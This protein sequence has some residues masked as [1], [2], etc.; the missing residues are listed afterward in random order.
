MTKDA[1]GLS[2]GADA[3]PDAGEA[4]EPGRLSA[5]LHSRAVTL[6]LAALVFAVFVFALRRLAAEVSYAELVAALSATPYG[7]L[8][9]AVA[10]TAASYAALTVYD[11]EGLAYAGEK[12]PYRAVAFVAFCAY[13]VGNTAGF[14]PLSGGAI[15]YRFYSRLGLSPEA[16]AKVI[17]FVTAAFGLGLLAVVVVA[18]AVS[19]ERLGAAIGV[20]PAPLRIA[21]FL[22]LALG[23]ALV[24][25]LGRGRRLTLGRV[26][27]ALPGARI[28]ASQLVVTALDVS[29]AALALYALLP[30]EATVGY[31][32]FLAIY[33]VAIGIGVLS[34]VPAGLGVFET[35]MV[36]ALG[37][38]VPTTALISSLL[39]YRVVY[40]VLPLVIAAL[41]V[42][43]AETRQ[44]FT[45]PDGQRLRAA[46]TRIA[47]PVLATLAVI[48]GLTLVL[49]SVTPAPQGDLDALSSY[50][51]LPLVEAA[52]FLSG[53]LGL[54]LAIAGRGLNQRLDGAWA[55]ALV[56]SLVSLVLCFAKALAVYEAAL[57]AVLV[58]ALLVTRREFDRPASLWRQRLTGP[59]LF[60]IAIIV[61]SAA[62]ILLFVYKD[63]AYTHE[64]WL[65]FEF[66]SDAPRS[67]RAFVGIAV[68]AG[69]AALASLLRP[70]RGTV[71]APLPADIARAAAIV[72]TQDVSDANLVRCADKS[73]LFSR[74]G[75][76][77]VMYGRHGRSFI[78]LFEPIGTPA[79]QRDLVW[80]FVEMAR[81]VGG[82]A[83]FYQVAPSAVALCADAGLQ[84]LK[85]GEMAV[86]DL[87]R[88]DLK[89]A[90]RSGLR[91]TA[92]R[93]TRDGLVFEYRLPE[94][95][96]AVLDEL[97]AISDEWL[98]ERSAREKR[99]S[100]GFFDD[101]YMLSQPVALLRHEG[102]IVAFA[103]VLRT[104]TKAEASID[105]M[106]FSN[107]APKSSME[108]LFIRLMEHM[109]DEGYRSF[110][111][112]MAPLSGLADSPAAPAWNR[113][114][115]LAFG[116]GGRFY[117]FK[118]LRAFKAK[119]DPE[120]QP[121]YLAVAGG[122]NPALA[123]ADASALIAG[124]FR[125]V[126][127]R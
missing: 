71:P 34:H 23:M 8:F 126:V 65:E 16:V 104:G 61:A 7:D 27:L 6:G 9:L 54:G 53:I 18:T 39:L 101:A 108:F 22:A 35:V 37:A 120:W 59:W 88:F 57:L 99:F 105:L 68:I 63:V 42:C 45:G 118:G 112:G 36:A 38:S 83:V 19:A 92:S 93:G 86:V 74:D 106:R 10:A 75:K 115:R 43:V 123:L 40:Y 48:T 79:A 17:G 24:L 67:L 66:E 94:A 51:P 15:R 69:A 127:S 98:A 124:G 114:G 76:G 113:I 60:A 32:A 97:R 81:E 49:S 102:R 47:P 4:Q 107:G 12:R 80:S 56:V 46:G 26:S 64:L 100:V 78:A 20:S 55:V 25:V 44:L 11:V 116:H 13:A 30:Q 111:L 91:Q 90:R 5:L 29:F 73:L 85:L 3:A 87:T 109:R 121:R 31:P 28:V 89:G 82:R 117:N 96:P 119:F 122:I 1:S 14:G 50:L 103:N 62:A 125:G 33:A 21:A 77:F 41:L 58:A 52:T 2:G 70:S 72:E 84:A 110:N 95:V